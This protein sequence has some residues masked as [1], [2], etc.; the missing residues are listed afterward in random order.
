M[1]AASPRPSHLPGADPEFVIECLEEKRFQLLLRQIVE[2][3]TAQ[4]AKHMQRLVGG[5]D[6]IPKGGGG[7]IG[8]VHA[9]AN[10]QHAANFRRNARYFWLTAFDPRIARSGNF[11]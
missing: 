9:W 4:A 8:R 11:P 10:G 3:D 6:E 7:G 2:R 5:S 1:Q